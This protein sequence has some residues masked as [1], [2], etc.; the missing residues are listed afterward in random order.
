MFRFRPDDFLVEEIMPDGTV[1]EVDKPF[2]LR[3]EPG[4]FSR[5]VL[6]K[7]QWNTLQALIA[8]AR[9]LR[10]SRKRFGFAGT[11]DRNSVST[12]LCSV[13]GVMPEEVLRARVKDLRILGA[14]NAADKV[15]LGELAGNRFTTT[16]TEENCGKKVSADEIEEKAKALGYRVP[17]FF[18]E[19]RFGS[20]R[21]NT[22]LVGKLIVQGKLRDAVMNYLTFVEEGEKEDARAARERLAEEKDFARALDYFPLYLKYERSMISHLNAYPKDYVGALRRLPR[23]LQLMF[24]HAYQS[25]LFNQLLEQRRADGKL[26]EAVKGDWWCK[27]D[28]NGF[29]K[30]GDAEEVTSK[31]KVDEVTELVGKNKAFVLGHIIGY[32]T[33]P[34]E[35]EEKLLKKEGIKPGD[36]NFAS[37]PEL[38]SKG[39]LRPLF[40]TMAGFEV[41]GK[42]PVKI[43]F[44]L[45]AGAYATV[46]L[47]ELLR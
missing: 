36:F 33:K 7:R 24:V 45:P 34:S 8:L 4:K 6:Q 30:A 21:K 23:A 40:V 39:S 20:M 19:Q 38:S 41:L 43:R 31:K 46:A 28:R 16:L 5:F 32:E 22:H 9:E 1:L 29:P 26:F 47:Q 25:W 11:K 37:M 44:L 12:Q 17:N 2:R 14:W 15:R 18:G 10:I 13:F 42:E 35:D 3:D 27:V